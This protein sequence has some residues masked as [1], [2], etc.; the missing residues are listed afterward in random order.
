MK[1]KYYNCISICNVDNNNLNT[2]YFI[3]KTTNK[4]KFFFSN[5]HI[6]YITYYVLICSLIPYYDLYNMN[7]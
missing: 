7:E 5:I 6:T 1:R 3:F 2:F 4:I